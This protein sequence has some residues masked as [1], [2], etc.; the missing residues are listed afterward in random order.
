MYSLYRK[1]NNGVHFSE[2]FG[3]PMPRVILPLLCSH[4]SSGTGTGNRS[5][6][7]LSVISYNMI[8]SVLSNVM[9]V[10]NE[11]LNDLYS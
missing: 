11:E 8:Y 2:H 6:K 9:C 5:S 4:L 1:S 7:E 3:F 10:H